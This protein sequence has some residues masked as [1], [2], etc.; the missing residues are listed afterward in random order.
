MLIVGIFSTY[1]RVEPRS[2]EKVNNELQYYALKLIIQKNLLF[3]I[4]LN[5]STCLFLAKKCMLA[6]IYTK[7]T[8]RVLRRTERDKTRGKIDDGLKEHFYFTFPG[9]PQINSDAS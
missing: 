1:I 7:M 6:L 8:S 2:S 3:S 5:D 4:V 9:S